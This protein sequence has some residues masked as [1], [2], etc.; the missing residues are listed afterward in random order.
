[1]PVNTCDLLHRLRLFL[2]VPISCYTDYTYS[3]VYPEN[4]ILSIQALLLSRHGPDLSR[5]LAASYRVSVFW[6]LHNRLGA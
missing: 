4:P 1:M 6:Q 3:M 5:G 2:R